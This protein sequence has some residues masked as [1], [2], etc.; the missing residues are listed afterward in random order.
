LRVVAAR[1]S[2]LSA[3]LG[4]QGVGEEGVPFRELSTQHP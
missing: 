3:F 4:M 2:S 1:K